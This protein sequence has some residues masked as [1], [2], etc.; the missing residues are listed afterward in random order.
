MITKDI[1]FIRNNERLYACLMLPDGGDGPFPLV[2]L[3]HGFNGKGEHGAPY[4]EYFLKAGAACVIFDFIGGS[5]DSESGGSMLDMSIDT[6]LLDLLAVKEKAVSMPEIDEGRVF[7][8]GRSQGA[9]VSAMAAA[10]LPHEVRGLILLYP[11]FS[12]PGQA[13]E[14]VPDPDKL[15]DRIEVFDAVVGKDYY[16]AAAALDV[17]AVQKAYGGPVL[18]IQGQKD[19]TVPP[20]TAETAHRNYENAEL[21]RLPEGGHGFSGDDFVKAAEESARFLQEHLQDQ[22]G[23]G[24]S[25]GFRQEQEHPQD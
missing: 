2:I 12:I 16:Y 20:E 19:K 18:I 24:A 25:S 6:E 15:P 1:S 11:A 5:M 10:K 14:M 3:S 21:I 17:E 8:F 7:L 4:A 13:R 23:A 22:T 9:L